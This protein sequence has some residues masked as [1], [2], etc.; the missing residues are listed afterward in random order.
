MPDVIN[1]CFEVIGGLLLYLNIMAAYRDKCIRGVHIIP[2]MF[3]NVWGIWNLY[4]Y[5]CVGAWWSFVGGIV[6]VTA[7]MAWLS[8]MLYYNHKEK[9]NAN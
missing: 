9:A 6:V 5:P 3:M 4:F 7:N 1:C 2:L 8:Q